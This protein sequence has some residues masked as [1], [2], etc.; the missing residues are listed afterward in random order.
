M[1]WLAFG[2]IWVGLVVAEFVFVGVAYER[3]RRHPSESPP[4]PTLVALEIS[5]LLAVC[6]IVLAGILAALVATHL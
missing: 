2:G 4:E 1:N 6:A 3:F 5:A